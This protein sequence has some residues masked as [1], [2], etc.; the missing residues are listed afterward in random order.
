MARRGVAAGSLDEL[1][2][3]LGIGQQGVVFVTPHVFFD[4]AEHAEFG[5]DTEALRMGAIHDALGDRRLLSNGSWRAS[6]ITDE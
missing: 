4:A 3:L 1:I 6:I 5:L 2:G